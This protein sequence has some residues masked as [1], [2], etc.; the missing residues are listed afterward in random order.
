MVDRTSSTG[1][2]V[3]RW[4]V[5]SAAVLL[6]SGL[7]FG[8]FVYRPAPPIP[9]LIQ[10][11]SLLVQMGMMDEAARSLDDVFR[12]EPDEPYAHL[13]MAIVEESRANYRGALRHY[14]AGLPAIEA[15]DQPNARVE[16]R[17]AT[18]LLRLA[19]GD[20]EGAER[21]AVAIEAGQPRVAAGI[22]IRAFSRL[23]RGVDTDFRQELE[24]AYLADPLD[25]I[26]RIGSG[27]LTEAIPWAPAFCHVRPSGRVL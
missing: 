3:T 19:G 24:R 1:R 20:F 11:A 18:A 7:L 14:E 9:S 15:S 8:G 23:G 10:N 6:G 17:V 12:R 5:W 2:D 22:L 21:D 25:P 26:F 4:V 16:F 13:L 27:F